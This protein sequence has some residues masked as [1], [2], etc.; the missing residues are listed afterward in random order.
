MESSL[1]VSS[2]KTVSDVPFEVVFLNIP[3]KR[4]VI[5]N[6][7]SSL[8]LFTLIMETIRSSE[9]WTVT[10]ATRHH[11]PKDSILR[12]KHFAFI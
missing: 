5:A 7:P 8:N 10:R 3:N 12:C 11:I 4:I 1:V 9:T 2:G 6:V